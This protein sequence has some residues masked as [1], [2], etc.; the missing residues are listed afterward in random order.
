MATNL[1]TA[2]ANTGNLS[3]MHVNRAV[4]WTTSVRTFLSCNIDASTIFGLIKYPR[5][6]CSIYADILVDTE[7]RLPII[8]RHQF[9]YLGRPSACLVSCIRDQLVR[10]HSGRVMN[11]RGRIRSR[12]ED[13]ISVR[14]RSILTHELRCAVCRLY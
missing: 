7:M 14:R 5:A 1:K 6:S 8:N 3:T 10:Q 13:A 2:T 9:D 12:D 11:L 4:S